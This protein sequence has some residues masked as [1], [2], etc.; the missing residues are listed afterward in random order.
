MNSPPCA[1]PQSPQLLTA[2]PPG[3]ATGIC[4]ESDKRDGLRMCPISGSVSESEDYFG[5]NNKRRRAKRKRASASANRNTRTISM[6]V[7]AVGVKGA[8][9][10]WNPHLILP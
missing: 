3:E 6:I 8:R 2:P 9:V 5:N 7:G 10:G 4:S 1:P